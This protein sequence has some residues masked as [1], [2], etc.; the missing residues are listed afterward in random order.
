MQGELTP[1]FAVLSRHHVSRLHQQEINL[2]EEFLQF[3]RKD[4]HDD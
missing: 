3:Y 4:S 1:L 2:E